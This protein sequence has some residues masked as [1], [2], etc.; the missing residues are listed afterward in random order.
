M[1]LLFKF[2]EVETTG[3]CFPVTSF[4]TFAGAFVR[5]KL[6]EVGAGTGKGLVEINQAEVGARAFTI[7]GH[8]WVR[9]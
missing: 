6:H 9:S 7:T 1:M 5:L 3:E 8:A 2:S 4:L